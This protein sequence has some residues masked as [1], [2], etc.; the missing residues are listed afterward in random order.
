MM[1]VAPPLVLFSNPENTIR[2]IL[3]SGHPPS[4]NPRFHCQHM[5]T[6]MSWR[7]SASR[8]RSPFPQVR[9]LAGLR[10]ADRPGRCPFPGE[11]RKSP[12]S[13]RIGTIDTERTCG[14]RAAY[15]ILPPAPLHLIIV[16]AAAPTRIASLG[17][18]I[19]LET[20]PQAVVA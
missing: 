14:L 8:Q 7:M 11:D 9:F 13:A 5:P 17:V 4:G 3:S 10:H 18:P 20:G 12:P 19:G 1:T 15:R 6:V 16:L 2:L